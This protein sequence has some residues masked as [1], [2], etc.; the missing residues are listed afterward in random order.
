MYQLGLSDVLVLFTENGLMLSEQVSQLTFL[1]PHRALLADLLKHSL[2]VLENLPGLSGVSYSP[3]LL[4]RF[5]AYV[6]LVDTGKQTNCS[7]IRQ[8]QRFY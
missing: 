7:T 6:N 8:L 2:Q 1:F 4:A 5:F 3:D